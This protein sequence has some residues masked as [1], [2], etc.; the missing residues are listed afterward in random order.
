MRREGTEYTHHE[1]EYTHHELVVARLALDLA[2][3]R[4]VRIGYG[5]PHWTGPRMGIRV[6]PSGRV[7]SD[8]IRYATLGV[9]LREAA[10]RMWVGWE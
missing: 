9:P 10:R 2:E 3:E 8:G 7:V 1:L 6:S 4:L 5:F